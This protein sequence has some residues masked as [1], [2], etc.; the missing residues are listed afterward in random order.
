MMAR[1]HHGSGSKSII[2]EDVALFTLVDRF[3]VQWDRSNP[4]KNCLSINDQAPQVSMATLSKT[5]WDEVKTEVER[6]L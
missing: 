6:L 3:C 5:D 2:F 4:C 1:A